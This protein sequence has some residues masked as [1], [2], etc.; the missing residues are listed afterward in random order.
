[1]FPLAIEDNPLAIADNVRFRFRHP[2]PNT[3]T[4]HFRFGSS[5]QLGHPTAL[6]RITGT[7]D[8]GH[9]YAH[10]WDIRYFRV[11]VVVALRATGA[12]RGPPEVCSTGTV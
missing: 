1:M 9:I 3:N 6:Y 4:T 11:N 10:A 7:W 12:L 2:R 8:H 5:V